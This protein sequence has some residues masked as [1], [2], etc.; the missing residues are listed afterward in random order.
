MFNQYEIKVVNS[1]VPYPNLKKFLIRNHYAK[2]VARASRNYVLVADNKIKACIQFGIPTGR[3][4]NIYGKSV[5]ELKKLVISRNCPKNTG[6]WF[7]SK[8]IKDLKL[9]TT[10]TDILTYADPEFGHVGTIYKASNFKFI[11]TQKISRIILYKGKRYHERI[12][13]QKVNGKP[14]K[15][16]LLLKSLLKQG[17]A[18][19]IKLKPKYIYK[20]ELR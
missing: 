7:I 3:N 10:Y 5:V 18:C 2:N 1:V 15:T 4:C 20:Y 6:S 11:G 9:K 19:N 8:C 17:K 14:T 12:V 16:S 13:Y